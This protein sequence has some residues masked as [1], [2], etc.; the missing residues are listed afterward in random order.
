MSVARLCLGTA[1]LGMPWYGLG[2]VSRPGPNEIV[3]ILQRAEQLGIRWFDTGAA[4]GDAEDWVC[5]FVANGSVVTKVAPRLVAL[6]ALDRRWTATGVLVHN[7]SVADLAN[8][9]VLD[10]LARSSAMFSGASVYTPEEARAAIGAGLGAIQVPYCWLDRRHGETMREAKAA[11]MMVFARQP[12]LQGLLTNPLPAQSLGVL[13][14]RV[15]SA[16]RRFYE[17]LTYLCAVEGFSR[18]QACLWFVLD[19]PADFVVCGVGS[20]AH[21]EEVAAAADTAPPLSWAA[22]RSELLKEASAIQPV[23]FG[24]L[25]KTEGGVA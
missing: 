7:P 18:V 22:L 25:W 1:K 8:K 23:E 12:F 20:V 15:S 24:S 11:G 2:S 6:G 10:Q 21:L 16:I 4:Y 9:D 14:R 17:R 19:S 13:E 5:E 3:A